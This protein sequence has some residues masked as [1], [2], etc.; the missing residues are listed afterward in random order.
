MILNTKDAFKKRDD[1]MFDDAAREFFADMNLPADS[2]KQ[3]VLANMFADYTL[4]GAVDEANVAIALNRV[5][6]LSENV[7]KKSNLIL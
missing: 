2:K 7:E 5:M 6:K 3:F 1:D 4:R